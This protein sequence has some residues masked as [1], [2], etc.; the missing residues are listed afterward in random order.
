LIL[1]DARPVGALPLARP[2]SALARFWIDLPLATARDKALPLTADGTLKLARAAAFP[3]IRFGVAELFLAGIG[4]AERRQFPALAVDTAL[5]RAARGIAVTLPRFRLRRLL[6]FPLLPL[7]L[8]LRLERAFLLRRRAS[9][10]L[11]LSGHRVLGQAEPRGQHPEHDAG[12]EPESGAA[13]RIP[14]SH[15][16]R[17]RVKSFVVH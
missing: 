1:G 10:S 3:A 8:A 4:V 9:L 11:L 5:A 14:G 7:A 6:A 17:Q 2:A 12:D 13:R 16:P 15:C